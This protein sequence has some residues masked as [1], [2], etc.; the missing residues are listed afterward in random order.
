MSILKSTIGIVG[1]NVDNMVHDKLKIENNR[2]ALLVKSQTSLQWMYIF[3]Q[4]DDDQSLALDEI[5]LKYATTIYIEYIT[6][7]ELGWCCFTNEK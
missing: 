7:F 1:E 4:F 2:H 3:N 5:E 6:I